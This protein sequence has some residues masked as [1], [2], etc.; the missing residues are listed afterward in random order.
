MIRGATPQR[1]TRICLAAFLV[2][3]VSAAAAAQSKPAAKQP[4]SS[5]G[6]TDALVRENLASTWQVAS[7]QTNSKGAMR[8]VLKDRS[9]SE[10]Q[11]QTMV[12]TTCYHLTEPK[13]PK[14]PKEIAF[15][16]VY[17]RTGY[18]FEAPDR[19]G[20]FVKMPVANVKI[21]LLGAT[22]LF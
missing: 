19:C 5:W 4:T 1:L 11:Y 21:A 2:A 12:L 16:N 13:A 10:S 18:V 6:K 15:V 14:P 17:E 3:A 22:H 9:I 8:V 20:E 7:V